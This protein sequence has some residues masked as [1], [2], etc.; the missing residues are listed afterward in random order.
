MARDSSKTRNPYLAGLLSLLV[1][2]LGQI[3]TGKGASGA[4]RYIRHPLYASL[5]LFTWEAFLKQISL[6][7]GLLLSVT[8]V[9]LYLT[10]RLEEQENLQNFGLEY[11]EYMQHTKMFIPWLF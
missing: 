8:I 4:Y 9:A 7:A 2:G 11:A 1:P 5:L 6:P 3:Y 10:A